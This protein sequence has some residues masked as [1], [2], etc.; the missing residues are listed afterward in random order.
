MG[1]F[2]DFSIFGFGAADDSMSRTEINPATGLPM[3]GGGIGGVDVGG[4]PYGCSDDSFDSFGSSFDDHFGGG[5]GG[6]MNDW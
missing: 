1:I 4:N 6:G 5:C 2:S 3:I